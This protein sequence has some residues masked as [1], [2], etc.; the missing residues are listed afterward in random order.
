M[1]KIIAIGLLLS[2]LGSCTKD[3][4]YIVLDSNHQELCAKCFHT[5]DER[6]AWIKANETKTPQEQCQ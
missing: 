1:K 2:A 6:S 5:V 4:C 3:K